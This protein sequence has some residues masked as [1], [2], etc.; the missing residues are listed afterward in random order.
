MRFE[1][2]KVIAAQGGSAAALLDPPTVVARAT[3]T[4]V[5]PLERQGRR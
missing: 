3:G 2:R 1:A 4:C 5:V